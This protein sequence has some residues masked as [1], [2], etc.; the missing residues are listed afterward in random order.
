MTGKRELERQAAAEQQQTCAHQFDSDGWCPECGATEEHVGVVVR[1]HAGIAKA[2]KAALAEAAS[3]AI[4]RLTDVIET[5]EHREAN[6][7]SQV[8]LAAWSRQKEDEAPPPPLSP[9][10]R[11]A[12]L[13]EWLRAPDAE[14]AAALEEAGLRR[15]ETT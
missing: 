9:E 4:A 12:K 8:I 13:L 2:P 11:R 15:K 10:E 5:G 14:L 7:A 3:L 1:T 6:E